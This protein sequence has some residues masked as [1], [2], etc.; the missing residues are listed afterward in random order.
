MAEQAERWRGTIQRGQ[1][2][3]RRFH[4]HAMQQV[5]DFNKILQRGE[6]Q[7]WGAFHMPAIGQELAFNFG[8]QE[9]DGALQ[10][11]FFFQ[12]NGGGKRAL[13]RHQSAAMFVFRR[14]GAHQIPCILR[15]ALHHLAAKYVFGGAGEE[16]PMAKPGGNAPAYHFGRIGD[17]FFPADLQPIGRQ[18]TGTQP[19]CIRTQ[20]AQIAHPG[21]AM[22]RRAPSGRSAQGAPGF[23]PFAGKPHR[24][25]G[26]GEIRFP[27]QKPRAARSI[28]W[29]KVSEGAGR[30]IG[31]AHWAEPC[32][33]LPGAAQQ[34]D[35]A[36]PPR[37]ALMAVA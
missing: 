12:G 19:R 13:Q 10:I 24:A 36:A 6:L 9:A 28:T 27:A 37:S 30:G 8:R 15:Q 1:Q 26:A 34:V 3:R 21:K 23:A 20:G 7:R 16:I 25:D 17:V 14:Q 11:G 35:H 22:R 18:G 4:T 29:P 32:Q 5:A 2:M 31:H 33:F